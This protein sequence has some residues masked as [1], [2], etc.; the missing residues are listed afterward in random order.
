[1]MHVKWL[2]SIDVVSS[3]FDGYQQRV[4]YWYR[5]NQDDPGEPVTRI[6]QRALMIPPGFPDFLTRRRIVDQ[7]RVR[8]RGRAWSGI[9][10]IAGVEL[11]VD[12]AWTEARLEPELGPFAWRG[13]S[14]EW[15]ARRGEHELSCRSTDATG[16]RQPH[17]QP[18]NVQGMGNNP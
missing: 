15:D 3:A 16:E 10:P 1:M 13:W 5:Q 17:E 6:R 8:V 7:G 11:G 2:R 9:A 18:W 12:G 4:A 14:A